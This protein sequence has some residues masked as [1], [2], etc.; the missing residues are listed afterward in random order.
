M[1][2]RDRY[3]AL[4]LLSSLLILV[5]CSRRE[6]LDDYP[7]T[8]IN[9]RLDWEGVTGRL[10]E[11]VRVIFY[12]KD[13]QGRKIDT[14]LPAKGGEMK[15]PPGHYLAVI[16]NYDTEVM[17][18]KGEDSYETIMACTGNCTGLEMCIRDRRMDALLIESGESSQVHLSFVLLFPDTR[19]Q[20]DPPQGG[21]VQQ[22]QQRPPFILTLPSQSHLDG[23][24]QFRIVHQLFQ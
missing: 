6:S 5:G 24:T 18:V 20:N 17:Q 23:E 15:V 11:G 2:I 7:V 14:Y 19:M 9:I 3:V 13:A 1:C 10:P 16:Y 4:V 8:G 21:S 12:P 22:R